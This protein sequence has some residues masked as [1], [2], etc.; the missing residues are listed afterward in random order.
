MLFDRKGQAKCGSQGPKFYIP[1]G[2][3]HDSREQLPL[4]QVMSS[5]TSG[6]IQ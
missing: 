3:S 4:T 6:V 5:G 1:D 2:V